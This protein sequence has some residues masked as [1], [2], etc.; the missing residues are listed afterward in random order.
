MSFVQGG[1]DETA[2]YISS[3][4]KLT[5]A[6]PRPEQR[7][8]RSDYNLHVVFVNVY[9]GAINTTQLSG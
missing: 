7:G 4:A 1:H 6:W 5:G 3:F 2:S 8:F 9:R